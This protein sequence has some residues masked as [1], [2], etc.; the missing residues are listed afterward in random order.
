MNERRTYFLKAVEIAVFS[1]CRM[2]PFEKKPNP[3]EAAVGPPEDDLGGLWS[4]EA[5]P[6]VL[7]S[8]AAPF[9]SE[10]ARASVVADP[11]FPGLAPVPGILGLLSYSVRPFHL[12]MSRE[13]V[14][15]PP[16]GSSVEAAAVPGPPAPPPA[17]PSLL[18]LELERR[19]SCFSCCC[20]L[21]S[22]E[23]R[24]LLRRR[25]ERE[26]RDEELECREWPDDE[27]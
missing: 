2:S 16:E 13:L 10:L 3:L 27:R 14:P 1:P 8:P 7:Q 4:D 25:G 11:W 20:C 17:P 15:P 23:A 18:A 21:L 19:S 24:L 22:R 9:W 26:E 6:M 12:L 5:G